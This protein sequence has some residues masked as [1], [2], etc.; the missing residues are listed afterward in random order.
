M[1]YDYKD[2]EKIFDRR[3]VSAA[4]NLTFAARS[5][6]LGRGT[7]GSRHAGGDREGD[8]GP[9]EADGLEL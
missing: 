1:E 4:A 6:R 8:P 5:D 9:T 2:R 7:P 3:N